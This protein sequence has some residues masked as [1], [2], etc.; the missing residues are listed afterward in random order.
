[1][2]RFTGVMTVGMLGGIKHAIHSYRGT[3]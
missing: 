1:M 3:E 2:P